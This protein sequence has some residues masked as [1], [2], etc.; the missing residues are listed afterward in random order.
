MYLCSF[1][2]LRL[3][4]LPCVVSEL[5]LAEN[6]LGGWRCLCVY[7]PASPHPH[8]IPPPP[9]RG[10][11]YMSAFLSSFEVSTQ[12]GVCVRCVAGEFPTNVEWVLLAALAPPLRLAGACGQRPLVE[13]PEFGRRGVE[14]PS[15]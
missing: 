12:D 1:P 10:S 11:R 8:P 13:S 6:G 5:A 2:N 7:T 4:R 9:Q 15:L 3:A 14:A